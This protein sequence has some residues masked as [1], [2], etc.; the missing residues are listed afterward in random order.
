MPLAFFFF[1]SS[2]STLAW[3][4]Q[5]P[6]IQQDIFDLLHRILLEMAR[7]DGHEYGIEPK[8]WRGRGSARVS[9]GD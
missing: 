5:K 7:H 3:I 4:L 2:S 9:A 6:P 8:R 1:F